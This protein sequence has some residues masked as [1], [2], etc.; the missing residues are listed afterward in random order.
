MAAPDLSDLGIRATYQGLTE[1]CS[2]EEY[3]LD[4]TE[5]RAALDRVSSAARGLGDALD[6]LPSALREPAR[7]RVAELLDP[8]H[9]LREAECHL[10]PDERRP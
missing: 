5:L 2:A 8:F 4:T 1:D 3:T 9:G 10:E 6:A 7:R